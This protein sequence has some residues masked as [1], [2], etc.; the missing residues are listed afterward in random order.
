VL[1]PALSV[2][3]ADGELVLAVADDHSP[4]AAEQSGDSIT[5][6]F[7]DARA[8]DAAHQ[9]IAAAFPRAAIAAREVDDEDW[10]RRSQ[11]NL[12]PITIGLLTVYPSLRDLGPLRPSPESRA[13]SPVSIII[14]PSMGF[15]TGHHATTRLCLLALQREA[16]A[17]RSVLDIGTGSGILAIAAA[18]LGAARAVGIDHDPDAIHAA[19]GNVALNPD[20]AGVAFE[21]AELAD[22]TAGTTTATVRLKADPTG[23]T[24]VVSGF[25]RT[26]ATADIVVANLTGALLA[27]EAWRLLAA[28]SPGGRLIVSGLLAAERDHVMAAFHPAEILWESRENEWVVLTFGAPNVLP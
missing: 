14:Q 5:I 13:W 21:V 22:L 12:Q 24:D 3:G 6:F 27:R 23:T 10:A 1:Y 20:A 18:C 16:L 25:S 17:G 19:R 2:T 28:V 26:R 4:S 9:A 15:G 7:R 8:R 11:E